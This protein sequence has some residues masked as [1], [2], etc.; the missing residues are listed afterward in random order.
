MNK[1]PFF[2]YPLLYKEREKLYKETIEEV[3]S[4]GAY[5]MQ[6]ELFNFENE[7]A[8]YLSVKHAIGVG[9]G[10]MAIL[11]SLIASGIGKGDEVIVPAH[12]FVSSVA[13]IYHIGAKPILVDCGEDHLIDA[14]SV[15]KAIN[16][17]SK[18]IMPVQLNGR[19]ANMDPIVEIA[20][21]NNLLIIEDSCQAFGASYKGNYAGTFGKAGTFS[22]FP[23]K[24]LGCF[25]DG[26]AVITDSDEIA[27]KVHLIRDH[28]RDPKDGKVKLFG[29]NT[30]L[31]NLQAAI[32][33]VKLKYYDEDISRRR[34]IA[35]IYNENL[36]DIEEIFLPPPP[37]SDSDHFDI[38][39]NYEVEAERRDDLRKYLDSRGIGTILPWG[40]FTVNNFE[41][42][43]FNVQLPN[44][45]RMAKK[46]M[47]LP[48]HTMLKDEEVSYI[49]KEIINFYK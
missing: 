16:E 49:T 4:K 44:T 47:L 48:L 9:D 34:E 22:F 19:V 10:T 32:L 12:T 43:G 18:A 40:G 14:G 26:G 39:Q 7:I 13:A 30:R 5:I 24:T 31:D 33:A 17:K 29:F 42:L 41:E 37:A 21:R 35:S 45:D 28:G 6:E 46:F 27:E 36:K 20:E 23:A 2:N 3:L 38:F 8:S 1:I 15:E 11:C 25:G